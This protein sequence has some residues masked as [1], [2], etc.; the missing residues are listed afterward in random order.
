LIPR[1]SA[2]VSVSPHRRPRKCPKLRLGR[3]LAPHRIILS[4]DNDDESEFRFI[5]YNNFLPCI[6]ETGAM[7]SRGTE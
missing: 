5:R 2:G 6:G 4:A 1:S 7:R 3:N